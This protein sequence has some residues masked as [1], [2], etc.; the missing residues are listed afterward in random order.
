MKAM[1]VCKIAFLI[2]TA[3]GVAACGS[4]GK[5][6]EDGAPGEPG[7]SPLPPVTETSEVTHINMIS[8]EIGEGQIRYEFEVLNE[9]GVLVNGLAKAEAKFAEKTDRGVVLNRDGAVG[10]YT[11][12]SKEGTTL[13]ALGEGHYELIAAMPAVNTASEGIV[14]LRVGGG[15]TTEIARSQPL[16]VEKADMLHTA[17][18]ETC[19]SCHVDYA[20]SHLKHPSYAAINTDGEADLVAGCLVCHNNVSRAEENGG[21]ATNTLQKIGHVNHQK[22]EKDFQPANC[23]TCHAEPVMN[24]SI[25]GNG[26]TDCHS[27]GNAAV[28]NVFAASEDFDIRALHASSAGITERKEIRQNYTS[29]TSAPYWD[30]AVEFKDGDDNITQVG[31][32]CT[33]LSVFDISGETEQQVNIAELYA[34]HTLTYAGAYI[35][36]YDSDNKT[37]V[38]R[39]IARGADIYVERESGTRSICFPS[40]V[41]GFE[42]SN[43]VAST[44]VTFGLGELDSDAA[45]YTGGTLKTSFSDVVSTDYYTIADPVATPPTFDKVSEYDRRHITD[46]NSCTTCHTSEM[47]FHKN[48]S[49]QEGGFDCVAC[50]NNGQDR[51]AGNSAPG[52]G[53]MVHSMHWGV[54]SGIGTDDSNSATRLNADNC[55]SCHSEG[56][57]LT[58][59]P[60]QYI[61]SKAYNGGTSGVMTSPITANCFACHNSD[62]ALSHMTQNGGELNTPTTAEWYTQPTAESCSTCHAEGK[63][64]GI[65]KFHN[66]ER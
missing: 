62:S 12:T 6:G 8:H 4:D 14:W 48:G 17:T 59:T 54:G 42:A 13:T 40:L 27:T 10:G 37:I 52:F 26:C 36:G 3:M 43:L 41:P 21:Y 58:K 20:Q 66:F 16:I 34:D 2:A 32:I 60:N 56:I 65:D 64:F 45:G 24:T 39:A 38:G 57:D 46:A 63:S 53:P 23:Y 49:Y 31:G 19:N 50:H 25:A 22:F 44:R 11:D 29:T 30:A 35:H 18:A 1:N 47:N 28:Q 33:D 15:D 55:V 61:L 51:R 9:E 7:P 5:D